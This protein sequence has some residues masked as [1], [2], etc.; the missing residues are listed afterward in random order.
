MYKKDIIK[1]V[2]IIS[3]LTNFIQAND[4][5]ESMCA[6][7]PAI[8]SSVF[9][10]T[11]F[12]RLP[13]KIMTE[14]L[15]D[16]PFSPEYRQ[17]VQKQSRTKGTKRDSSFSFSNQKENLSLNLKIETNEK[18]VINNSQILIS[19]IEILGLDPFPD[20]PP[21]LFCIFLL[22]YLVLLSRSNLPWEI[23]VPYVL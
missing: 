9:G 10:I 22:M 6:S 2:I 21:G 1:S 20:W 23:N 13:L 18:T 7:L 4:L 5:N 19:D 16:V 3:L 11:S 8:Q 17:P 12:A 14:V 15:K